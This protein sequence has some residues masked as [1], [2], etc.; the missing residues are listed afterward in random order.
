[1]V[2]QDIRA[3][4]RENFDIEDAI[5]RR[6]LIEADEADQNQLLLALT[7]KLYDQIVAK[8]DDIDFGTIPR[9][10][11]DITK[12]EN[13]S[14]LVECI[15]ILRK[16]I[17]ESKEDPKPIDVVLT[18]IEN[19]KTRI[20]MFSKAFALGVE[21]PIL[22][23]NSIVLAIVSSVSFLIAGCIEYIKNPGADHFEIALNR[24]AYNKTKTNL[25][26]ENLVLFNTGCMKGDFDES[27]NHVI[28]NNK[29]LHESE[30]S[31]PK[32]ITVI[33]K[34]EGDGEDREVRVMSDELSRIVLHDD[35]INGEF[36]PNGPVNEAEIGVAM[37]KAG[38]ALLGLIKCIL[39]MLRSLTYFFFNSK[40]K[41]SNYFA[42]QAELLEMNAYKVQYNAS[43]ADSKR[44]EIFNRQM[45]LANRM[46]NI[47]NAFSITYSK[48]KK[49]AER[50]EMEEKKKYN[51]QDFP[52]VSPA[53]VPGGSVLL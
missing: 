2:I 51:I 40:Q 23:Y 42:I 26:F 53:Y 5:T 37:I 12:I 18:A 13:Y 4:L 34:G 29:K 25:L 45:K 39:P 47:S 52:E 49:D 16:I 9:S 30:C 6:T 32:V 43:I 14:Q 17:V 33:I 41:V 19:V 1:M 20:R 11:G 36:S 22:V 24:V 35:D 28:Q 48:S 27:M 15:D 7:S 21:M 38:R 8:V 46:R 31:E 10:R 50:M 44:Q 3:V